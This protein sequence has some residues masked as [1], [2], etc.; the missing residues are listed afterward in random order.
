LK[1]LIGDVIGS[2]YWKSQPPISCDRCQFSQSRSD[3][4]LPIGWLLCK[5]PW[6]P[7]LCAKAC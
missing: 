7:N 2:F 3:R 4:H 6:L 5:T 1:E